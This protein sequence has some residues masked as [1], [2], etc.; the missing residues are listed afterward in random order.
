M[1]HLDVTLPSLA[2][3]LA[4]DEA[5]L[6]E[7]EAGGR[8]VLRTWDWS[9]PAV[10]LG[11]AGRLAQE[12]HEDACRRDG[13]PILRRASGGGTVLLGKGCLC[14]SLVLSY[15]RAPELGLVSSSYRYILGLIAKGLKA[16]I[17]GIALAG[18]SDL[19][20]LGRKFSGNSQQRKRRHLLHHGTLLYDFDLESVS[21]YLPLSPRQPDYR[22]Q[23]RHSDFLANLPIGRGELKKCLRDIWQAEEMTSAWPE[24]MVQQLVDEKYSRVDWLR[25]R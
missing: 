5:L 25:R 17:P 2:A 14:F 6:L 3:N 19:A 13:V 18:T 20:L 23:R 4:L 8:Q 10:V 12:V 11:A 15:D 9:G 21:R 22:R 1:T 24:P 7:A 16:R